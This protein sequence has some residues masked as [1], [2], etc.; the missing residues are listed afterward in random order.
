MLLTI[1]SIV[2]MV[3]V[4]N[5][6][7]PTVTRTSSAITSAGGTLDDRIKSDIEIIHATGSVGGDTAYVW[8]KNVG[9]NSIG[10]IERSD[11]F[12]GED[13][14]FARIPPGSSG[15]S[16]PCWE[17]EIENATQF[18]PTSTLKIT[19]HLTDTLSSG[20]PYYVKFTLYNAVS[21][22]RYFTL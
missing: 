7:L 10:S 21:D 14:S 1:A 12:F 15:C 16:A 9:S 20:T 6:V 2:A 19:I 18:E 5:A 4:I 22:A 11:L 17:Y 3:V 13:G 8:V